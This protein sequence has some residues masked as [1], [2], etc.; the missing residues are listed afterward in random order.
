M[1]FAHLSDTERF[2]FVAPFAGEV[3]EKADGGGGGGACVENIH[4]APPSAYVV[5]VAFV[6]R[7]CQ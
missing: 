1:L 5:P 4:E 6:A 7:T 3:F 2:W